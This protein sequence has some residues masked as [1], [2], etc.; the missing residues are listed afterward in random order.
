[1]RTKHLTVR[2]HPL[3]LNEALILFAR[4]RSGE[5]VLED[6]ARLGQRLVREIQYLHRILRDVR[7]AMPASYNDYFDPARVDTALARTSVDGSR[8]DPRGCGCSGFL[9]DPDCPER[10]VQV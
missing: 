4:L 6:A 7:G 8:A 9:H 2:K 5:S 3:N 10:D 1:M